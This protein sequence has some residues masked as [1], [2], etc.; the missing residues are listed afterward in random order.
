MMKRFVVWK[1]FLCPD[2]LADPH[3]ATCTW[4][5]RKC[6]FDKGPLV[7]FR[8]ARQ[9]YV[10]SCKKCFLNH[11]S[12]WLNPINVTLSDHSEALPFLPFAHFNEANLAPCS[13][14]T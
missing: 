1:N 8:G 11:A 6:G 12:T 9:K 14:T 13:K 4:W 5:T 10:C 2:V 7:V 3:E